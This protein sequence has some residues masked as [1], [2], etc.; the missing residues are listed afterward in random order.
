[1][2]GRNVKRL[3]DFEI[4]EISL[5]D[6]GANQ[7]A[8]VAIAKRDGDSDMTVFDS[9]GVE[10][11]EDELQHGD[12][13]YTE[14]GEALQFVEDD[15][16]GTSAELDSDYDLEAMEQGYEPELIGKASTGPIGRGAGYYR[17]LLGAARREAG[18]TAR[19]M[20]RD[21][22]GQARTAGMRGAMQ[23]R[24]FIQDRPIAAVATGGATGG[25]LGYANGRRKRVAKSLGDDVL[26]TLSKA[27]QEGDQ[28]QAIETLVDYVEV[29]KAENEQ[30]Q[31]VLA[32]VLDQ[33]D[34]AAYTE[35][36]SGYGVPMD[37][38]QLGSIMKRLGAV[39]PDAEFA[40]LDRVLAGA[41][42]IYSELGSAGSGYTSTVMDQ[43]EAIAGQAVG[44]S[45]LSQEQAVVALFEANPAAYDEYVAETR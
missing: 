17:N 37:P 12:I 28:S 8:T 29:I 20:A 22:P 18:P 31:Q 40:A 43:I 11:F 44:K 5:V 9:E 15:E 3:Y 26:Q 7:H 27:L 16:D 19:R 35:L 13:V 14:D 36:A 4:D 6:R 42:E 23:S 2:A 33:R 41:G 10:V 45:D 39:L 21:L 32:Q 25:G 30:T 38:A 34:Q 1:M 24:A